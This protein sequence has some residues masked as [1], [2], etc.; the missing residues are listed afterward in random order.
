[1]ANIQETQP[2]AV[3][4]EHIS[5]QEVEVRFAEIVD[6]I[7]VVSEIASTDPEHG[8]LLRREAQPKEQGTMDQGYR[9]D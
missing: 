3:G 6:S 4:L 5:D 9:F 1:M 8:E 2:R 7:E